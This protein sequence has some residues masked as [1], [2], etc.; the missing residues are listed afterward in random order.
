MSGN[1]EN[2]GLKVNKSVKGN[3]RASNGTLGGVTTLVLI[4]FSSSLSS[5][6]PYFIR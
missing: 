3:K 4:A 2:K 6:R 1:K 5:R